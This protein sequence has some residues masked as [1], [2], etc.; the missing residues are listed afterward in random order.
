[1]LHSKHVSILMAKTKKR[2]RPAFPLTL[3]A[4]RATAEAFI[5][6]ALTAR[7]SG[8]S[9][10]RLPGEL[11]VKLPGMLPA[12]ET[13]ELGRPLDINQ[14]ADLIGCSPWTVRRNLL[15]NGLPHFR[16]TASSKLI[17]YEA[18]VVRWIGKKQ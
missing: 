9:P 5:L 13:S 18:Q 1:S 6:G 4:N 12:P 14:V 10:G 7:P 11:P 16:S 15:H 17:F 8:N 2:Q 3:A